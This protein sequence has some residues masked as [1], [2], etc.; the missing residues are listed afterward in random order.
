M[1]VGVKD[2]RNNRVS[3]TYFS[4]PKATLPVKMADGS[5]QYFKWGRRAKEFGELPVG[6]CA[7]LESI[8][9]GVWDKYFPQPVKL[10]IDEFMQ[11]DQ[12]TGTTHWFEIIEGNIAQGMLVRNEQ[13]YRV[14][15]VVIPTKND[16]IYDKWPRILTDV[17]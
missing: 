11:P 7:K 1:S 14:Y 12:A 10:K 9:G 17:H 13:E 6:S 5:V 4:N 3:T 2:V 16:S 8:K 15:I